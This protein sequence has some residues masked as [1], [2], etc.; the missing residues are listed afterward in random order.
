MNGKWEKKPMSPSSLSQVA[1]HI[2]AYGLA[3]SLPLLCV[4]ITLRCEYLFLVIYIYIYI[5]YIYIEHGLL[6]SLRLLS[7]LHLVS[8]TSICQHFISRFF[9]HEYYALLDAC[10]HAA[11]WSCMKSFKF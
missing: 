2:Y 3:R 1:V 11:R 4:G 10:L 6:R 7:G 9:L 8:K 5:I